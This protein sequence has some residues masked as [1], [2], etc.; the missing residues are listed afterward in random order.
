MAGRL[1]S[2]RVNELQCAEARNRVHQKDLDREIGLDMGLAQKG[3]TLRPLSP[4]IL[5]NSR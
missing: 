1:G 4:S 2:C 3:N 5:S